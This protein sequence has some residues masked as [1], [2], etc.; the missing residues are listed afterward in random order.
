MFIHAIPQPH[1]CWSALAG[2]LTT[3]TDAQLRLLI[4]ISAAGQPG[5]PVRLTYND[6]IA[7]TG[8]ARQRI[9]DA[10]PGLIEQGLITRLKQSTYQTN[11]VSAAPVNSPTIKPESSEN[12]TSPKI[13]RFDSAANRSEIKPEQ[14]GNQ[15]RIVQQS[16][17]NPQHVMYV[18]VN[19][20]ISSDD[21]EHNNIAQARATLQAAGVTEPN[22]S[23]CQHYP[24]DRVTAVV[25]AAPQRGANPGGWIARALFNVWDVSAPPPVTRHPSPLTDHAFGSA[26]P[27][28]DPQYLAKKYTG[29]K[30]AAFIES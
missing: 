4:V 15:T 19:P 29:G 12:Q 11:L 9:A 8:M 23:R 27:E 18:D 2:L 30:F 16:N 25:Q 5:Q 14:S 20:Q 24:L 10:L 28:E 26:R 13:I 1:I 7:A 17:Q 3:L 6:L 21:L 22:L